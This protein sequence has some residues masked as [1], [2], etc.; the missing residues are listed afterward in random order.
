MIF[1]TL[2]RVREFVRLFRTHRSSSIHSVSVVLPVV[3]AFFGYS[4]E[5]LGEDLPN[6]RIAVI[7]EGDSWYFDRAAKAFLSELEPLA[8][9]RYTV[10]TRDFDAAAAGLP[11]AF[12]S[13]LNDPEIDLIYAAG[14][15]A[16]AYAVSLTEGVRT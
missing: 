13:A 7:H 5:T 16:S 2:Q 3:L 6:Y 1:P 11:E 8:E 4:H 15:V 14:L 9:D 12:A 10:A